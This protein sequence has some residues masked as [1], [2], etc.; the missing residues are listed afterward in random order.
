MWADMDETELLQIDG[1]HKGIH[2]AYHV[3]R[4]DHFIQRSGKE[5]ELLAVLSGAVAHAFF[6]GD[7][8]RR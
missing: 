6:M 4:G 2:D 7:A 3:A 1:V 8:G 5:A